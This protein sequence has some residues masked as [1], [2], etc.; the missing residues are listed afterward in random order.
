MASNITGSIIR[1]NNPSHYTITGNPDYPLF[2]RENGEVLCSLPG[3]AKDKQ[4]LLLRALNNHAALADSL[5]IM[6]D[7]THQL[8][9]IVSQ[10]DLSD[11]LDGN[12]VRSI[13]A[14]RQVLADVKNIQKETMNTL[15]RYYLSAAGYI[16]DREQ[17][18][19]AALI[20]RMADHPNWSER[21]ETMCKAFNNGADILST[22]IMFQ[23]YFK[24]VQPI[25]H[26]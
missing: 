13:K 26:I 6:I 15:P 16:V 14:A 11:L 24:P 17:E 18:G 12:E 8:R 22:L 25:Y 19:T 7:Y 10:S 4:D 21:G 23:D 20:A 3:L 9:T 2:L 5:K 1:M